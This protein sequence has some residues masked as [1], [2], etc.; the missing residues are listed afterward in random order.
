VYIDPKIKIGLPLFRIIVK[1][2]DAGINAGF[3]AVC[4]ETE[5]NGFNRREDDLMLRSLDE[6]MEKYLPNKDS[7]KT[8]EI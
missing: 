3:M 7:I 1:K 6:Y 4:K 8:W 5:K 2:R